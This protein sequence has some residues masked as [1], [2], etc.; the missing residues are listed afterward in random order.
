[1]NKFGKLSLLMVAFSMGLSFFLRPENAG[2]FL[3]VFA[4]FS[5]LGII[6]A[7]LSK[8]WYVIMGGIMLNSAALVFFGLL[9]LGMGIGER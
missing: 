7:C 1:M 5:L 3:A 2:L 9:V 8:R 6:F 4:V